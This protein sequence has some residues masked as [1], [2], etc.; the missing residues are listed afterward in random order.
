MSAIAAVRHTG[1]GCKQTP[2]GVGQADEEDVGAPG[3]VLGAD[4][5]RFKHCFSREARAGVV[6]HDLRAC[7]ATESPGQQ[8]TQHATR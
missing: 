1:T 4:L 5:H 6:P 2:T 8:L 7:A 3:K